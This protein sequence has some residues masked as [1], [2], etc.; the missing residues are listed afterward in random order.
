MA[1]PGM[2]TNFTMRPD[3]RDRHAVLIS[4]DGN[5]NNVV[6]GSSGSTEVTICG[7]D[8]NV[9]VCPT[10]T[11]SIVDAGERMYQTFR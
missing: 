1:T 4:R 6:M 2:A 9:H 8:F 3:N 10:G 5:E 7:C 11:F